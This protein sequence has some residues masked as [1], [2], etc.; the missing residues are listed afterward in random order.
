MGFYSSVQ[1]KLNARLDRRKD[2]IAE[3]PFS[4]IR[5]SGIHPES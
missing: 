2:R 4:L 3:I 5:M 1:N